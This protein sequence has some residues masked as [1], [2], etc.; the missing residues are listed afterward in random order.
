MMSENQNISLSELN[1][2]V[3]QTLKKSFTQGVRV[4]A[5]ISQIQEN[6]SGHAYL[7]LIEKESI[8]DNLLA[9]ARATIWAS[10]YRMIKPYFRSVTGTDLQA[11][12]KV[13]LVVRVEFHEVYGYSLN[14][15]DLDPTYTMGDME[16]RR[17]EIIRK[18]ED[19][20]V[21][22]MNKSIELATVPQRIAIISSPTA[23]GYEDF[24]RQLS[25]NERG[26][27]FYTK[28]FAATMQGAETSQSV[29][30]AL[31][32]IAESE[33]EFDA[34]VIM[35]GGG[36]K[37]D[38]QAFNDYWIALNITQFPLPIITGIGHDRDESVADLVA[39]TAL[40][41]PTAVAQFFIGKLEDFD[42]YLDDLYDNTHSVAQTQLQN[43]QNYLERVAYRF[44]PKIKTKI[45]SESHKLN[46]LEIEAKNAVNQSIKTKHK[47]I[48]DISKQLSADIVRLQASEYQ[49]FKNIFSIL[50]QKVETRLLREK[51]KLE[52]ATHRTELLSPE[53]VLQR[54]YAYV[55]Q[56]GKIVKDKAD[57][58]V[59]TKIETIMRDGVLVSIPELNINK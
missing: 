2:L 20:G 54:G 22:D 6:S 26:Y 40:K 32:K 55:K 42:S 43:Q 10:S 31:D 9:K 36:S 15:T 57:I 8:S 48:S 30:A 38:L 12:M 21:I 35:R 56:N 3:A 25:E 49:R 27:V 53:H 14:I 44:A 17:L 4:V 18:L 45:Q 19:E 52:L 39:H 13:L 59:N 50:N 33:T 51:H 28:L 23:A 34:V 37:T 16:R 11:G 7:E 58:Q 5:E 29:V 46:I 1:N 41:T 47:E 24:M